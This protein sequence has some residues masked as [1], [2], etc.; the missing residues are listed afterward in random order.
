MKKLVLIESQSCNLSCKYCEL[1]Q[2]SHRKNQNI[3]LRKAM[4]DNTYFNN[5]IKVFNKQGF[6][7]N[8]I[9][10]LQLWGEETLINI[11]SFYPLFEKLIIFFPHIKQLDFST[12]F[13]ININLLIKFLKKID[14]FLNKPLLIK[15][16]ISY[17]GAYGCLNSRGFNIDKI[18]NN[19]IYFLQELNSVEFNHI[20]I[21]IGPHGVLTDLIIEH[22]KDNIDNYFEELKEIKKIFN[23]N[24]SNSKITMN[25]IILAF[26]R[27]FN[28][29][30]EQ[31]KIFSQFFNKI[32][33]E[34]DIMIPF[35]HK[36]KHFNFQNEINTIFRGES[37]GTYGCGIGFDKITIQYNGDI[38]YCH[39]AL[40]GQTHEDN[41]Y[42]KNKNIQLIRKYQIDSNFIPN[43]IK[44][45]INEW[46]FKQNYYTNHYIN[47]HFLSSVVNSMILLS[48]LNQID[49][50][51]KNNMN[52]ITLH[53]L[54][55]IHLLN[56]CE[57]GLITCGTAFGIS[58]G[59]IRFY[60][61][62]ILNIIEEEICKKI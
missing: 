26:Q 60:A 39:D 17:D 25:K 51:Y 31:G 1:A 61:N 21:E 56:C 36:F 5:I 48:S 13:T 53:A 52:K 16:Q 57:D 3:I 37:L 59:M 49:N 22:F 33:K 19:L 29:T 7:R 35:L 23:E 9:T 46:Y 14:L 12:N 28:A 41:A 55:L 38:F 6:S 8:E 11:D 44:D 47:T 34:E 30:T 40:Y 18:H 10:E 43:G 50:S 42:S 54:I 32:L 62:G 15:L 4:E 27:P 2:T 24:N 45:D 20:Q 58:L